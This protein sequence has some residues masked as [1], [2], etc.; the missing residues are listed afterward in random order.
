MRSSRTVLAAVALAATGF[1]AHAAETVVINAIDAKGAINAIGTVE[2]AD[3]K[4]GL[5]I[6]PKLQKLPPGDHGF[7]IHVKPDCGPGNGPDGQPA[8]GLAA[9][10]HFDPAN[11]GK[12]LGPHGGGHKGDLPP[13]TVGED[14]KAEKAVTAPQLKLADVKGRSIMI[15]AGGD[16][17]SDDPKPLGGGGPRIACGVIN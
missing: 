14:G 9:G 1:A 7:H 2:L 4:A 12:H 16:N 10:G 11:A 3:S 6:T 5:T 8:A 17:F 13:L 15:H